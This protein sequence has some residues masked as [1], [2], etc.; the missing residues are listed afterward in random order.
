VDHQ[1]KIGREDFYKHLEDFKLAF[2][3]ATRG[4][5]SCLNIVELRI[6][7]MSDTTVSP[8]ACQAA[9]GLPTNSI[10]AGLR[11]TNQGLQEMIVIGDDATGEFIKRVETRVGSMESKLSGLL[12]KN[13]E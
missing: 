3:Q 1:V 4:L 8:V 5:G 7:V 2:I 10:Q 11:A 13:K 12:A 6:I 9:R